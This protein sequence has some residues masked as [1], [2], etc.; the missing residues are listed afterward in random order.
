[1]LDLISALQSLRASRLLRSSSGN[2]NLF[3]D[4]LALNSAVNSTNLKVEYII[5]LLK[6]VLNDD[7]DDLVWIKSTVPSKPSQFL[8]NPP[9]DR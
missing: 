8:P 2:R 5:P 6:V 1:M 7:P 4:L 9:L 3:S